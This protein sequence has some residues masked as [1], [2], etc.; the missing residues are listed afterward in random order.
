MPH[1]CLNLYSQCN[2][3]KV[4]YF[5]SF[6]S[7]LVGVSARRFHRLWHAKRTKHEEKKTLFSLYC[8]YY[9]LYCCVPFVLY[10]VWDSSNRPQCLCWITKHQVLLMY[11]HTHWSHL[12]QEHYEDF[13]VRLIKTVNK[14]IK[15]LDRVSVHSSFVLLF[16]LLSLFQ[17]EMS[18]L[19]LGNMTC[20][21]TLWYYCLNAF[22]LIKLGNCFFMRIKIPNRQLSS[23]KSFN[24]SSSLI[25]TR[26]HRYTEHIYL[27]K[28]NF[29]SSWIFDMNFPF[30]RE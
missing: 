6:G 24:V 19:G 28:H 26:A 11:T 10:V 14:N 30:L 18:T 27:M 25:Y 16:L 7:S 4:F 2:G 23:F 22:P 21:T 17:A 1:L 12:L 13:I 29:F 3:F 5:S 15:L 9:I 8:Y 20:N